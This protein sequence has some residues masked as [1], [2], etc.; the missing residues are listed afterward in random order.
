MCC[1]TREEMC[2]ERNE[3]RACIIYSLICIGVVELVTIGH[4]ETG[5][6]NIGFGI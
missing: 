5:R 3:T 1:A 4:G 6:E 2:V